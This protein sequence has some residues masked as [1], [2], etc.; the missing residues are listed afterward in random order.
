MTT[1]QEKKIKAL[2]IFPPTWSTFSI[3]TGIPQIMGYL[4]Q[5]GYEDVEALD[6]NIKF[7]QYFCEKSRL[8]E[9]ISYIDKPF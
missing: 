5:N 7:Y 3:S 8:K 9:L 4:I 1:N 6:L 2:F